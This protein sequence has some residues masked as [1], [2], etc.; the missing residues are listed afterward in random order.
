MSGSRNT[1]RKGKIA[2]K[3][4]EIRR[5]VELDIDNNDDNNRGL[6]MILKN[7]RSLIIV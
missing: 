1:I 2:A 7:H 3:I 5:E 4:A 6:D